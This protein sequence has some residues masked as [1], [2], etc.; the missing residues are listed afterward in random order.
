MNENN[1]HT[2]HCDLCY[3]STCMSR[4][5]LTC[6]VVECDFGCGLKFHQCKQI[7]HKDLCPKPTFK[8]P[9]I[10]QEIGCEAL[11]FRSDLANH[12]LKCPANILPDHLSAPG[13]S[14]PPSQ[15][16]VEIPPAKDGDMILTDLPTELL[17]FVFSFLD[18]WTLSNLGLVNTKCRDAVATLHN[19]NLPGQGF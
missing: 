10:N 19:K 13:P 9:C 1:Y 18:T 2:S 16:E 8:I 14:E 4:G 5:P 3:K 17:I 6:P 15:S 12:M 7:E 11:I